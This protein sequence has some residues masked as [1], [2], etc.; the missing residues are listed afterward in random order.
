MFVPIKNRWRL[1]AAQRMHIHHVEHGWAYPTIHMDEFL[2]LTEP[3]ALIK[4][5]EIIPSLQYYTPSQPQTKVACIGSI[6][7]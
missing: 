3:A 6:H 5:T 4:P 7:E 2:V 1:N